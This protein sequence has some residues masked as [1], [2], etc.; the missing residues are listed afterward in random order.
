[1]RNFI[2]RSVLAVAMFVLVVVAR[3]ISEQLQPAPGSPAATASS[4]ASLDQWNKIAGT[5]ES[6]LTAVAILI[7]GIWTWLLFIRQ[8]LRYPRANLEHRVRHWTT[9]STTVLHVAVRVS[10]VG[11]VLI[12]VQSAMTRLYQLD[13]LDEPIRRAVESKGDAVAP[14]ASEAKWPILV[15]RAC[16]WTDDSYEI[17]PGE[18]DEFLF[19]FFLSS[20]VRRVQVYSHLT[21]RSKARRHVLRNLRLLIR[22]RGKSNKDRAVRRLVDIFRRRDYGWNVSSVYSF[23]EDPRHGESSKQTSAENQSGATQEKKRSSPASS[24]T[25]ITMSDKAKPGNVDKRVPSE[26]PETR[27][28]PPKAPPSHPPSKK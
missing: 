20:D 26:A 1:M 19:D 16:K 11:S 27:Q 2:A 17:E 3:P 24:E 21:N 18:S 25:T 12:K 13:P 7:A 10:N 5:T 22:D 8:R 6:V 4:A 23:L 14:N 15:E 9:G 28:G